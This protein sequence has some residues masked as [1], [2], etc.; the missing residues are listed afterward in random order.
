MTEPTNLNECLFF[1]KMF[2]LEEI[3]GI[4]PG[5]RMHELGSG[6]RGSG[7]YVDLPQP[8]I[9]LLRI[10]V[11]CIVLQAPVIVLRFVL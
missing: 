6:L 3:Q 1:E 8:V 9:A 5:G 11:L 4:F 10:V 2:A 7:S